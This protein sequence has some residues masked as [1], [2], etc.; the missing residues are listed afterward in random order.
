MR[1]YNVES[2][3]RTAKGLNFKED[4]S[5]LSLYR[6]YYSILLIYTRIYR[7]KDDRWLDDQQHPGHH[8]DHAQHLSKK[9]ALAQ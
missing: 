6:S 8:Q 4:D 7:A 2:Q 5:A 9:A 3:K 1:T